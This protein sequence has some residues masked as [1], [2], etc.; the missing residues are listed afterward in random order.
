LLL[1]SIESVCKDYREFN[2]WHQD[3]IYLVF[4]KTRKRKRDPR[5]RVTLLE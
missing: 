4:I 5:L 2:P 3:T 1:D